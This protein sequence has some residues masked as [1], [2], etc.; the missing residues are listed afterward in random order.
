MTADKFSQIATVMVGNCLPA[1]VIP[2][3]VTGIHASRSPLGA[4]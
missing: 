2:V 4:A 1:I 3:L